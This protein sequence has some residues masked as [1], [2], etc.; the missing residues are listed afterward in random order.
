MWGKL[1]E[2][3]ARNYVMTASITRYAQ[4]EDP[5]GGGYTQIGP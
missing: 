4:P 1:L 5:R 2:Y 3:D